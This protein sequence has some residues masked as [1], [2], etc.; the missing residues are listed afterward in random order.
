MLGSNC[1]RR[2]INI[3]FVK[4]EV[5]LSVTMQIFVQARGAYQNTWYYIPEVSKIQ[6]CLASEISEIFFRT[7]WKPCLLSILSKFNSLPSQF[8]SFRRLSE[9]W[10]QCRS[11]QRRSEGPS[12]GSEM[13]SKQHRSAGRKPQQ[14]DNFR[15]ECRWRLRAFTYDVTT[16]H[17]YIINLNTVKL[18]EPSLILLA[19]YLLSH[20]AVNTAWPCTYNCYTI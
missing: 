18:I 7:I 4:F 2:S 12:S 13:G 17:R 14:R 10:R 9:Y 5:P 1:N 3:I 6:H 19:S 20:C 16:Q 8:I 15:A 11:R